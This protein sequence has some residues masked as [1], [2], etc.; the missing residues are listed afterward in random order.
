MQCSCLSVD[1]VDYSST[2]CAH[3]VGDIKKCKDAGYHTAESLL[4]NTLK[5]RDYLV[6]GKILMQCLSTFMHMMSTE[7]IKRYI[8]YRV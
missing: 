4:M 1:W 7:F 6:P 2:Y 3:L 8:V 5:V